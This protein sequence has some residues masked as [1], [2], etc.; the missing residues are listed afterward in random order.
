MRKIFFA[1]FLTPVAFHAQQTVHQDPE[2]INYVSQVS[3]DSL[4][5]HINSW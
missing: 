2:I 3:T 4:K 5:S 1:L